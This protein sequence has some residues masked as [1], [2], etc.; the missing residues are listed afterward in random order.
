METN[1]IHVK[2]AL[3]REVGPTGIL[4]FFAGKMSG[5]VSHVVI[6]RFVEETSVM[7]QINRTGM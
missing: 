1:Q 6:W 4:G 7:I 5:F 2:F 3:G